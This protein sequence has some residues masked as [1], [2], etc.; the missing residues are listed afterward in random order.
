MFSFNVYV[1]NKIGT[2]GIGLFGLIMSVYMFAITIATS[3]INLAT[4]RLVV[5]E[6]TKNSECGNKYLLRKCLGYALTLGLTSCVL[7]IIFSPYISHIALH[8]KVPS[9]L[10][11]VIA[12]SLPTISC[13][14][15]INGYFSGLRKDAKNA[16]TRAFEQLV[17]IGST[18]YYFRLF[19]ELNLEK[20]CLSLVLGETI[21]EIAS[22]SFAYLLYVL[23]KRKYV[24]HYK[25]KN[26]KRKILKIALPVAITSYIRSGLSSLKHMLIPL[27]LEKFGMNCEEAI[28]EYGKINGM[29]MPVLMFPEVIINSFSMLLIPEFSY[30]Y[31]KKWNERISQTISRIFKVTSIFSIGVIGVFFCIAEDISAAIYNNLEIAEYIRIL[32]PL[33]LFMYLDGI[34]DSILK[35][36]DKQ[37]A[38]MKCNVLDLFVSI[39]C[40]YFL[41]PL[42]GAKG[43][44]MV[45]FIS[46]LLNSCISLMILKKETKFKIDVLEWVLKPISGILIARIIL[47]MVPMWHLSGAVKLIL[48]IMIF[49]IIYVA[50][51][52]IL[53]DK[54]K[55]II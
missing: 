18:I 3:G 42:Y 39:I 2:E 20:A 7:L 51:I 48:E 40:I 8:D 13:S 25:G 1:T 24:S 52:F 27:R 47:K 5:Q 16:I 30:Y 11:F 46:E 53:K 26:Y 6:K 28:S 50:S 36:L 32:C 35:G 17:K 15:A 54:Q 19:K 4:V 22:F 9:Y 23:E 45:I 43:Y 10:F 31:A 41:L 37:V 38:V 44:L 14:S 49:L 34:V 21:S 33:L 55:R 29:A 12:I